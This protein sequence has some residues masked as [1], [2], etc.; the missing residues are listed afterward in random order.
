LFD[1][2]QNTPV[3]VAVLNE[4]D[5]IAEEIIL[6]LMRKGGNANAR[7][8]EGRTPLHYAILEKPKSNIKS[9]LIKYGGNIMEKDNNGMTP[10]RL[11]MTRIRRY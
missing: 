1:L 7:D 6:R 10:N 3:H 4:N 2:A 8:E 11:R 5:Q 9:I